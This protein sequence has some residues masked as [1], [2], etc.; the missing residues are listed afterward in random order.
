MERLG[1]FSVG[2]YLK[3]NGIKPSYQRIKIF[4]YLLKFKTHPT[5]DVIYK[6]LS[7]EIQTLS[8]TTVYNTLNL[9]IE[10]GLVNILV[11]EENETRYD[12]EVYHHAHFKCNECESIYD[13]PVDSQKLKTEVLNN[14]KVEEQHVYFKGVCQ[15]CL[16]KHA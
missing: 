11:I 12:V 1:N 8:K 14:F 2:E 3:N 6:A 15:K 16:E 4:E 7:P 13:L 9:F 10:N 5:V